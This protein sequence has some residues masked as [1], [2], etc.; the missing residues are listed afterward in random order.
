MTSR[1]PLLSGRE[2]ARAFE[3]AGYEYHHHS[4]SHVILYHRNGRH[5]SIP[6]HCEPGRGTLRKLVRQ[7]GL[8]PGQFMELLAS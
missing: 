7:A 4:G 5:L 3:R 6:D 2:A 1:L 8:S